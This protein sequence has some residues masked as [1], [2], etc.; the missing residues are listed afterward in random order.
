MLLLQ[1][2]TAAARLIDLPLQRAEDRRLNIILASFDQLI[3]QT[4]S[5]IVQGEVN[6][7]DLHRVNN[8]VSRYGVVKVIMSK[9][10]KRALM[11][12]LLSKLQEGTYKRYKDT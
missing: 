7:F 10:Q 4:R 8:F 5:S 6:V 9:Q 2:S 12:P 1:R 11:R 3:K